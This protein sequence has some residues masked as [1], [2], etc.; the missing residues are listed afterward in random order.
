MFATPSRRLRRLLLRHGRRTLTD[1]GGRHLRDTLVPCGRAR[2]RS[3]A[4]SRRPP[5]AADA[6]PP[7]RRAGGARA[8]AGRGGGARRARSRR[9]ARGARRGALTLA[10]LSF[11]RSLP[12]ADRL[13]WLA[14][15]A[16][17]D[18]GKDATTE[19]GRP[20]R[21]SSPRSPRR[22]SAPI[23]PATPRSPGWGWR[24]TSACRCIT[25]ARRPERRRSSATGWRHPTRARPRPWRRS[26]RWGRRG[27]APA[28]RRASSP[29][30]RSPR[31]R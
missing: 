18:D 19:A 9:C 30:R 15:L 2:K 3:G 28:R 1:G 23:C 21:S 6:G 24:A 17:G 5:T 25:G 22:S 20:R 31:R 12:P 27:A 7:A 11:A 16:S 8:R 26:S 13:A 10:A 29:R 4:R 14:S